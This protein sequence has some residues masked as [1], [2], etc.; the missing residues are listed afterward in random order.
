MQG[1][2]DSGVRAAQ[3]VIE[4]IRAGRRRRRAPADAASAEALT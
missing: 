2:L 1:A 3:E 4:A